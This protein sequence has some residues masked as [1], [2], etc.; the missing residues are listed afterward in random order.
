MVSIPVESLIDVAIVFT[1]VLLI[2][3]PGCFFCFT[4]FIAKLFWKLF[5]FS[6]CSQIGSIETLSFLYCWCGIMLVVS[7]LDGS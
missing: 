3:S 2:L 4:V 6:F 1:S 5:D 7:C